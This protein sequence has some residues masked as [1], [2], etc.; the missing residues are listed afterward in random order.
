M[1]SLHGDLLFLGASIRTGGFAF[2]SRAV[3]ARCMGFLGECLEVLAISQKERNS[4]ATCAS[5]YACT[6]CHW[7]VGQLLRT[8]FSLQHTF[9][10]GTVM[11]FRKLFT[12]ASYGPIHSQNPK[13]K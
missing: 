11:P 9:L 4:R 2:C 13:H 6:G 5:H 12:M 10:P 7:T 3:E 1:L 8:N